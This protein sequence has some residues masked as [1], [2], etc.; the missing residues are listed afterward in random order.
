M[1]GLAPCL[2]QDH[3]PVLPGQT[4]AC[5]KVL[6]PPIQWTGTLVQAALWGVLTLRPRPDLFPNC[7]KRFLYPVGTV[8]VLGLDPSL[9]LPKER[10]V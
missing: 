2:H 5:P 10:V 4:S 1:T 8:V 9:P 6:A 7:S 3:I